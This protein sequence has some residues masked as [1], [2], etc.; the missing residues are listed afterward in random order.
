MNIFLFPVYFYYILG[1]WVF[2]FS[3][4]QVV[5]EQNQFLNHLMQWDKG[6]TSLSEEK[7]SNAV[8]FLYGQMWK[9]SVCFAAGYVLCGPIAL[10]GTVKYGVGNNGV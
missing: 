7:E 4:K 5:G 8:L 6:D 3:S 9:H 1:K 10:S 2:I